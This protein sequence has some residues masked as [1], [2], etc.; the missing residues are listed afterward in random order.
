MIVERMRRLQMNHSRPPER[1]DRLEP[2]RRLAD[3][4]EISRRP[5]PPVRLD[6]HP[7]RPERHQ[8]RRLGLRI[9]HHPHERIAVQQQLRRHRLEQARPSD[10]ASRSPAQGR[11]PARHRPVAER[12][13]FSPPP[14]HKPA[15]R[16]RSPPPAAPPA[17]RPDWRDRPRAPAPRSSPAAPRARRRTA[18]AT[19]PTK[20][21]ARLPERPSGRTISFQRS[22]SSRRAANQ[23]HFSSVP[24]MCPISV[25][26]SST[27]FLF[28]SLSALQRVRGASCRFAVPPSHA[29]TPPLGWPQGDQDEE[30]CGAWLM[31]AALATMAFAAEAGADGTRRAP[32]LPGESCLTPPDGA[33]AMQSAEAPPPVL[34]EGLGYA[35]LE[36]DTTNPEARAWFAQGVRLI[37]AFD[38]VEAIRAFQQAQRLD[39]DLRALPFRRG[40]GA[41]ADDQPAAAHRRARR[42]PRRRP[43]R[44]RLGRSP[45]APRPDPRPRHGAAHPR[46]RRL[47]QRGLC[48]LHG[49]GG[50]A[51]AAGRHDPDHGRRRAHGRLGPQ[52]RSAAGRL[53]RRSACSSAS[54]P[55]I[56]IMAARS[57][58]TSTSPTGSIA[59]ISPCLMPIGSAGSR[60]R[61]AT[62]S[63]CRRTPITASAAIATRRRS[64]SRRSPPTAPSMRRRGRSAPTIASISTATTCT[65]RSTAPSPAATARPRSRSRSNI[66]PPISTGANVQPASR[67]LGSA[68]SYAAGLHRPSP[69]CWRCRK[70]KMRSIGR[71]AI[72][73]AARRSPAAAT[74]PPSAPRPR[75]I[76]A[77]RE[78]SAA[79]GLGRGGA[80]LA[81]V[82][83][84][85][86]EGR[87]AMLDRRY[88]EAA[89]RLSPRDEGPARR[90]FRHGS[91]ALLVFRPP[92]PRR[93]LARRRRR[94]PPPAPSS[95]PASAAGPTTPSPSTPSPSPTAPSATRRARPATSPA[96]ARSGRAR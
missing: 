53:A 2:A 45:L 24:V 14:A 90:R 48:R 93:R 30:R 38:E 85:V 15:P 63:T 51:H 95:T 8:L 69:R 27:I 55:A 61:R 72:M 71:C 80:R 57:I 52:R 89:D 40:L 96:R 20:K 84:G 82:A 7:L 54:S 12:D 91:A 21:A 6:P 49:N 10:Q 9:L 5:A 1:V 78:G 67:L 17:A 76:A 28:G 42:R 29:S 41:R 32:T 4:V 19:P 77:L 60:R 44:P 35:G 25:T 36:P 66:A 46:R 59:S 33:K 65:S 75:A 81:E 23:L 11:G 39:P 79:P 86:L 50:A 13:R 26:L 73:R 16:P 22:L 3:L 94:R 83:Q 64:T 58:I 18:A 47:R 62:S 34:I 87:A 68:L 70:A 88:D 92:Q 37:W 56:R 43:P 74:P 31:A